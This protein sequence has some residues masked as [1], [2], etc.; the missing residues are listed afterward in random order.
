M[1]STLSVNPPVHPPLPPPH[2][3]SS[4]PRRPKHSAVIKVRTRDFGLPSL[5]RCPFGHLTAFPSPVTIRRQSATASMTPVT[6]HCRLTTLPVPFPAIP[7]AHFFPIFVLVSCISAL[8]PPRF[9]NVAG[10][11]LLCHAGGLV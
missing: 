7:G 8:L 5:N 4:H 9:P 3:P 6:P 10:T 2:R 1:R 11:R